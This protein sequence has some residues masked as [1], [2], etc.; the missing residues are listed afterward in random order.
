M[1]LTQRMEKENNPRNVSHSNMSNL[2][3]MSY[4]TAVLETGSFT[5]A[6]E[7][8]GITKAVVSQQVARLESDFR[9]TLFTRTT[10]K[11]IPTEAGRNFYLRC[12]KILQE[13]N[14]AFDEL[15]QVAGEPNGILKITAPLDYGISTVVPAI[16]KFNERFPLCK[17]DALLCDQH[18]DLMTSDIE[19]AIRVGWI[20]DINLQSRQ[21]GSF[22][23][24][25]VA[26]RSLMERLQ[27]LRVPTDL[28]DKPF[29]VHTTLP[30]GTNWE[31]SRA[32]QQ[33]RVH[34]QAEIYLDSTLAVREAVCQGLGVSVLPEYVIASDLQEGSLVQLLPQWQL[35]EGGIHAVFPPAKF[36]SA[37]VKHFVNF[38]EE[39]QLLNAPMQ[40]MQGG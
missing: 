17:V 33:E 3:R 40:T 16:A 18:V 1:E 8:L 38:L 14:I 12:A 11:V 15:A 24:L 22:R 4:F 25:L 31:F 20:D 27:D 30:D 34:V 5:A 13:A 6:A 7:R 10:R 23:Q 9:T 26:S 2:K 39:I 21:I 19:L 36:R 37:K 28:V 32:G 29:I 35:P